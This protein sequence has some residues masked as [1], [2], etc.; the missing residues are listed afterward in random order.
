VALARTTDGFDLAEQDWE[1]RREGNVLGLDQ[2]GLPSLRVASL[3][4]EDDRE[5]AVR[6]RRHAEA[7][8]DDE[9]RLRP[10]DGGLEHEL[11][12]GWLRAV[13]TGEVAAGV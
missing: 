1:I 5:L 9:G 8:L 4:R 2:S 6:A 3:A 13:W 10:G 12:S 7:L 11:A